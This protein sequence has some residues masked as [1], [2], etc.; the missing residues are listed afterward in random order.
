MMYSQ[1]LAARA[2]YATSV[3]DERAYDNRC[4]GLRPRDYDAI[5][6]GFPPSTDTL[7]GISFC[8][9]AVQLRQV[10]DGLSNTLALGEKPVL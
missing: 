6:A 2:D 1:T 7:S 9:T 8:G 4:L 5:P 3:G 10:T